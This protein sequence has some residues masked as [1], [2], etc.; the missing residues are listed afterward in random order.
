MP[1]MIRASTK[2][3][4][5]DYHQMIA[6]GL[7]AGRQVELLAGTV[8]EM[9]PELSIHRATHRRGAR[10]LETLLGKRGWY[11]PLRP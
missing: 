2:W 5:A 9:A 6:A 10:Y 8:V 3:S 4:V 7:R 11:L 1:A